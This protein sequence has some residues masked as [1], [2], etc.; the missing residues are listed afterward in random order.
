[1]LS[2]SALIAATR[3]V[4]ILRALVFAP[5]LLLLALRATAP[6]ALG[7]RAAPSPRGA[8]AGLGGCLALVL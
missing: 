1:M 6:P 5:L 8:L 3:A 4:R 2:A 7:G